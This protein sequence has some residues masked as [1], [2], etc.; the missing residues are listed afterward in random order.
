[1]QTDPQTPPAPPQPPE[2]APLVH[3]FA[4]E[5]PPAH[6]V[7]T[8]NH[9]DWNEVLAPLRAQPGRW[10]RIRAYKTKNGATQAA[11]ELRKGKRKGFNYT[12]Y[13]FRGAG[14]PDNP[15]RGKLWARYVPQGKEQ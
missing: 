2:E 1:M 15:E 6:H 14:D 11:A 5:D 12:D 7:G 13:E 8:P 9:V 3:E 4:W 10:G